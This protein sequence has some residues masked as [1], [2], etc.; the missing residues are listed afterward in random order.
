MM[1]TRRALAVPAS[2]VLLVTSPFAAIADTGETAAVDA[3]VEDLR[4]AMLSADKVKL[5]ALQSDSFAFS[6]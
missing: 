4:K 1:S 6:F 5:E 3:S 2:A